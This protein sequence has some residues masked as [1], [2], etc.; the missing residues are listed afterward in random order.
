MN[1]LITGGAGFIGSHLA[2]AM[3]QDGANVVVVDD[4]STGSLDNIRSLLGRRDFQFVRENVRNASTMAALVD[5]CDVVFHLA[6]AVGVQLIVDRPVHTIET[7][8]HGS[9]VI[10]DLANKFGRKVVIASTSEVYGKSTKVPFS[11]DDDTTLG[12]TRYTRWSYACSKMVDE[13]L[14]LAYRDQYGLET[15]VCRFFNT[16]G[17]RQ[18]GQYGM[19]V[20]RF[21]RAALSGQPLRVFGS[22][23][24]SRC[25]CCIADVIAA[26]RKLIDCPAAIGEVINVGSDEPITIDALAAKVITLTGS[27]SPVV[28]ISYEEAY[29]RPFDDMLVRVPDL[30]KIKR[31][32]GYRPMY[33]LQ[34]TLVQIIEHEK[35]HP[36]S[37]GKD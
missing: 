34:Q 19:V 5:R 15:I 35:S 1:V 21:V 13:F 29:G 8:I 28:R 11:E 17:P 20:P 31:L 9:E 33:N 26:L 23:K 22:G 2:E 24:Q 27:A 25:F 12:C 36:A 16:I 30:T 18:T 3:V 14:A 6:A 7:N 4:L 10:L 37:P 32:I